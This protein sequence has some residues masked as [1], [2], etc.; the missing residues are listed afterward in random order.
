MTT[1][2]KPS[3]VGTKEEYRIFRCQKTT[4]ALE[5]TNVLLDSGKAQLKTFFCHPDSVKCLSW[6]IYQLIWV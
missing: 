6:K 1:V 5:T 3:L 2:D 4:V